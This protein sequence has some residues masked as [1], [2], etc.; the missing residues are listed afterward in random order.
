MS[1][2]YETLQRPLA[3]TVKTRKEY[4]TL[5]LPLVADDEGIVE[6]PALDV[7]PLAGLAAR[8]ATH[9]GPEGLLELAA[10]L[11]ADGITD[12]VA[13]QY[14]AANVFDLARQLLAT[15][16]TCTH[17]AR[18]AGRTPD[19]PAPARL[20]PNLLRGPLTLVVMSV[21][22]VGLRYYEA[23]LRHLGAPTWTTLLGLIAGMVIAGATMQAIGWRVSLAL[24][25]GT[26]Q[27]VRSL[28]LL[29][30]GF[31]LGIAVLVA[32]VLVAIG[33]ALH[34]SIASLVGLGESCAGLAVLLILSGCLA[35]LERGWRAVPALGLAFGGA[36]LVA[37]RWPRAD[38]LLTQI[39]PGFA[40]ALLL[41]AG[42]LAYTV[43]QRTRGSFG[44]LGAHLPPLG[45]L[46]YHATPYLSYG[47]LAVMY[48]LVVQGNG[49]L[50]RLPAGWTRP[51]AVSAVEIAHLVS[52]ATLVLTQG[53]TEYALRSFWPVIQAV[54]RQVVAGDQRAISAAVWRFLHRAERMLL[55][56]QGA[57]ALLLAGLAVWL[58][59]IADLT[60][61]L[62]SIV[63]VVMLA[64]LLGY[65]LLAWGLLGCSFLVTLARPWLAA[66]ALLIAS[67]VQAGSSLLLG[68]VGTFETAMGGTVIGGACLV[69]LTQSALAR[70]LQQGD[71]ALYQAF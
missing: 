71:Y 44:E 37:L 58:W 14:G 8:V 51:Q 23:V 66:R 65:S 21:L 16:R 18:A 34:L 40:V 11:E 35:L 59:R 29:G 32:G 64:N 1:M 25:Q 60:P 15:R 12:A 28:L 50:A 4:A 22:L 41:L 17:P 67:I 7:S 31:G 13:V 2:S 10:L 26:P 38:P 57:L 63:P 46:L 20:L 3:P 47:A 45:Q 39:V 62:G 24:S 33:H 5:Q 43:R 54:Q 55:L 56:A 19:S 53:I 70:L 27:A 48:V 52:L 6:Q 68:Q 36:W 61:L 30:L 69:L 49:W 42:L 9:V